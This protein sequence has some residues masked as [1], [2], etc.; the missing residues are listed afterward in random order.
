MFDFFDWS[1]CFWII[2]VI[3]SFFAYS[4]Y[5]KSIFSWETHPHLYSWLIWWII[6][7]TIWVIQFNDNAWI[8]VINTFFVWFLCL[9]IA[10]LA[11]KKWDKDITIS[12]KVYLWLGLLSILLWIFIQNPLY[13]VILLILVDI[14]WFIPTFRKLF[15]NPYGENVFPYFLSFLGYSFSILSLSN[16][17]FITWGYV[18]LTA[19]FNISLYFMVIMRRWYVKNKKI[20]ESI[21]AK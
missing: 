9:W 15:K 11:M 5:Y 2:S 21:L 12:D 6:S 8:W 1:V 18:W 7:V 19:L 13:S 14:F 17:S 16:F 4:I 20:P 3:F 10:F